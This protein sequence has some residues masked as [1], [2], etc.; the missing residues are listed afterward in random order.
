M[1]K[2]DFTQEEEYGKSTG[3]KEEE[4]KIEPSIEAVESVA[5][6]PLLCLSS[7]TWLIVPKG[8]LGNKVKIDEE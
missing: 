7:T 2:I 3:N 4:E 8:S 6:V 5:I 1:I